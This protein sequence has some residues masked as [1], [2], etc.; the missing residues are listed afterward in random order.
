M[1]LLDLLVLGVLALAALLGLRTGLLKPLLAWLGIAPGL[2]GAI[3]LLPWALEEIASVAQNWHPMAY[4]LGVSAGILVLGALAGHIAGHLLGR[5]LHLALPQP[6]RLA[7]RVAGLLVAAAAAGTL[8]WLLA[9]TAATTPGWFSEA[10]ADS[11][12]VR[13]S[14]QQLPAPPEGLD[15][16]V[17]WVRLNSA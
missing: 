2:L 8:A 16:V 3:R 4:P 5:L 14:L 11:L 1:N 13:L 6:L 7:D 15:R 9:P 10:A 17:A 12:L